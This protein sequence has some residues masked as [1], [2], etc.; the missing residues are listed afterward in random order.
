LL[1][2]LL[3]DYFT[4]KDVLNELEKEWTNNGVLG[5][6]KIPGLNA[7]CYGRGRHNLKTEIINEQ[8]RVIEWKGY[9]REKALIRSIIMTLSYKTS[10]SIEEIENLVLGTLSNSNNN[11][12]F[13][14]IYKTFNKTYAQYFFEK[15]KI[16][17]EIVNY[18]SEVFND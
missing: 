1:E 6:V 10:K 3:V 2:E 15:L 16:V 12:F 18:E 5:K 9:S 14:L 7:G 11:E 8:K 17:D 13:N 4:Q